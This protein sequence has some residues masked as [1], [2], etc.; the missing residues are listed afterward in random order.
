MHRR[1]RQS[2][3]LGRRLGPR[4]AE[5]LVP[6]SPELWDEGGADEPR[7]ACH[8]YTHVAL[9]VAPT[10][11]ADARRPQITPARRTD[12][13]PKAR[14]LAPSFSSGGALSPPSP[15]RSQRASILA[16]KFSVSR[17]TRGSTRSK[18][19]PG[20]LMKPGGVASSKLHQH[21]AALKT[22]APLGA[23]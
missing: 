23:S 8:E 10:L 9:L 15:N 22:M 17:C 7:T 19:R 5:H 20:G 14:K 21:V 3:C 13:A 2:Q 6:R 4:E 12:N 16:N 18:S 1:A 11:R